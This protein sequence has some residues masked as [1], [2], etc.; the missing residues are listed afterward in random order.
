MLEKVFFVKVKKT[1][2]LL[3]SVLFIIDYKYVLVAKTKMP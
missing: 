3:D 1:N 2:Y